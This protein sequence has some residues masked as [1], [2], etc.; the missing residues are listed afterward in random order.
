MVVHARDQR[1]DAPRQRLITDRNRKWWTLA[2]LASGLFMVMLD[3]TVVALALPSIESDLGVGLSELEWIINAYSL[4]FA[5]LLLT[6]GKLADYLGRRRVFCAGLFV[7]TASSLAC[8]LAPTG[9]ALIAA[10]GVQ[11]VGAALML[12]ATLSI[13]TA[14]FEVHERGAAIGIWAGISAFALAIGPLL[15]GLL[16]EGAGWE[17]IFY[18]NIPVGVAA[19]AAAL[20][21]TRE[22]R[23][24]S[25]DQRLDLAGL[26]TS[27]IAVFAL[28]FGLIEANTY[29]WGSTTIV[30]CFVVA[31]VALLA[32]IAVELRGRAAMID[33]SLFRNATFAGA[34]VGG[35]VMFLALFGFIFFFSFY[36][37]AV[38]RYSVLEAGAIFLVSTIGLMLAAPI[39]GKL[40][41]RVGARWLATFGMT[42]FGLGTLFLSRIDTQTGFWEMAPALA[43]GGIGF[44]ILMPPLTAAVL[45]SATVDKA[46]V[47]SG[48]MQSLRQLGGGLG[49]AVMGAIIVSRVGDLSP[50]RPGFA[51]K[52]VDGLQDA[53][54]LGAALSFASAIVAAL[55]I[56]AHIEREDPALAH[57]PVG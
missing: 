53:L 45:A 46:G 6:G 24:T 12:P 17:W 9:E 18:I 11:G 32:F 20:A 52:F 55:S 49:V 28:T 26:V 5:V 43:A 33:L 30:L 38:R 56:R 21:I 13:I 37:Q 19:F 50:G 2:I 34:N 1:P 3:N 14:T 10:R 54:L 23:D 35:L 36:L 39:A 51:E 16:V 8:G 42:L 48:M 29:G 57:T 27:A 40:S 4:T 44:G 7:F 47:A 22:S 41:D 31:A 15:G 25:V